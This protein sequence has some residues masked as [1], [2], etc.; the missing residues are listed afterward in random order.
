MSIALGLG[1]RIYATCYEDFP[2]EVIHWAK[3]ALLD[4]VG[5]TLAGSLEPAPCIV[6]RTMVGPSATGPSR[7]IGR[8]Y[9][10]SISDAAM[11]NGASS[12]VLDFD[13]CSNTIGGHPTVSI[14]PALIALAEDVRASG[15]ALI[16]AYVMGYEVEARIGRAVN[17]HHYE[18][19]WHPTATIGVFGCAAA[20]S[21]LLELNAQ[22][23]ANA[24]AIAASL[25]SGLKVNFGTMVK[26]L[27]VGHCARNGLLAAQL[28]REGFDASMLA[29]EHKQGF[30]NVFNGEGTYK[31]EC[32]LEGWA[33][34]YDILRPGIA[35]KQYPCCAS[36]HPAVDA[37]I[38]LV[39][40]YGLTPA[41][42]AKLESWTHK[43][44]LNHTNRPDPRT[45][46]DAKFS[47][48]YCVSR[49]VMHG[50]VSLEHFENNAHTDATA[51][52]MLTKVFAAPYTDAQFPPENH[53]GAEVRIT[54]T[55]GKVHSHK[56]D[57]PHG[58][59]TN[60]PLSAQM[61]KAKFA[62]CASRVMK[63]DDIERLYELLQGIEHC[64]DIRQLTD[65]MKV[66]DDVRKADVPARAA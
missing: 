52:S 49:A 8:N 46:L 38:T 15:K 23:I 30:F 34:P 37:T 2:E 24:I 56:V 1:E 16:L 21:K 14:L 35:I 57:Q 10:A 64:K 6:E 47:V 59:T 4:Y 55:D 66:S 9:H 5:V 48:Q 13:D 17:F 60:N 54:T 3:I 50:S 40:Q 12:H 26:S 43:R 62:S 63:A 61:L 20:C 29:F 33:Q 27:H 58:R 36:T 45:A 65:A 44:R 51:R 22:Q 7:V 28:A 53:F 39:K 18:K 42:V 41:K 25:A 11:I 19:G 31:A 32:V